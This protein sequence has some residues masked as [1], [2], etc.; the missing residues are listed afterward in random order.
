[1]LNNGYILSSSIKETALINKKI[2]PT[3]KNIESGKLLRSVR[4]N[5][6]SEC[7]F[8]CS[9]CHAEVIRQG[10]QSQNLN[11][12]KA[13]EF[14]DKIFEV[15]KANNKTDLSVRFYGGEPLI[16]WKEIKKTIEYI[17]K[18]KP[19][20]FLVKTIL[21]TNG[22]L[23][24]DQMARFGADN[25]VLFVVSLDGPPHIHDKLRRTK[26]NL[27]TYYS[28]RNGIKIL[29]K[30]G[31][32]ACVHCT[33]DKHNSDLNSLK[34]LV[35]ICQRLGVYGLAFTPSFQSLVRNTDNE[36]KIL[37]SKIH[38]IF[39]Y[40]RKRGFVV[41]GLWKGVIGRLLNNF[42]KQI[43]CSGEGRELGIEADGS[44][45]SCVN[46]PTTFGNVINLKKV[47]KTPYYTKISKR[48]GQFLTSC[49]TCN[50]SGLCTG[51]CMSVPYYK[52]QDI[53]KVTACSYYQ[54]LVN[55]F[56]KGIAKNGFEYYEYLGC[57]F[58]GF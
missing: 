19:K 32:L 57:G 29:I 16:Y 22:A 8:R 58:G 3:K 10:G 9:Y 48:H 7:N 38:R 30:N 31:C 6:T 50:L 46:I 26:N 34:S 42:Q 17:L 12:Y 15:L 39:L 45:T 36:N 43:H 40:A 25:S 55:E 1:M 53:N 41:G 11:F 2:I 23:V 56:I 47:F 51:G 35:K 21:N 4:L 24:N 49:S 5:W 18:K 33:I 52:S 14:I 44:I 13:K 54:A 27:G 37:A 28:V 20:R